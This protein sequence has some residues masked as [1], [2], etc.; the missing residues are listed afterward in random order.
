[1]DCGAQLTRIAPK[2]YAWGCCL[3]RSIHEWSMHQGMR[4][5]RDARHGCGSICS[6]GRKSGMVRWQVIALIEEQ[7]RESA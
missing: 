3:S 6:H 1:M 2:R 7:W 5:V 4:C